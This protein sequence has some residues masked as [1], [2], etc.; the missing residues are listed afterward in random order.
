MPCSLTMFLEF[1]VSIILC[2]FLWFLCSD[3]CSKDKLFQERVLQAASFKTFVRNGK[4]AGN[5][6]PQLQKLLFDSARDG[7][8]SW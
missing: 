8:D 6:I 5:L 2:R 3:L 4:L 1:L 7:I